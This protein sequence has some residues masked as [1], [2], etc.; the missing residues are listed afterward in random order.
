MAIKINGC[1]VIDDTKNWTGNP[2]AASAPS[3]CA[4]KYCGVS[5]LTPNLS[6]G[7]YYQLRACSDICVCTITNPSAC[8]YLY[9]DIASRCK[10]TIKLPANF[11]P[12]SVTATTNTSLAVSYVY[13]GT[14]WI[15]SSTSNTGFLVGSDKQNPCRWNLC[16]N[17]VF[18]CMDNVCDS[19]GNCYCSVYLDCTSKIQQPCCTAFAVDCAAVWYNNLNGKHPPVYVCYPG[20]PYPLGV[21]TA[22][23]E[24]PSGSCSYRAPALVAWDITPAGSLLDRT[25]T[26]VV[27]QLCFCAQIATAIPISHT[28]ANNALVSFQSQYSN[29]YVSVNKLDCVLNLNSVNPPTCC[30]M[31][32]ISIGTCCVCGHGFG[33]LISTKFHDMDKC[34]FPAMVLAGCCKFKFWKG[35]GACPICYIGSL[36]NLP[37]NSS[38]IPCT[39]SYILEISTTG[40]YLVMAVSCCYC[41]AAACSVADSSIVVY[42]DCFATSCV[43]GSCYV[44]IFQYKFNS[45][46]P[47]CMCCPIQPNYLATS[48]AIYSFDKELCHIFVYGCS[49]V[50]QCGCF[51]YIQTMFTRKTTGDSYVTSLPPIQSN[52]CIESGYGG[53]LCGWYWQPNCYAWQGFKGI[54]AE[55]CCMFGYYACSATCGCTKGLNYDPSTCGWRVGSVCWCDACYC[56]CGCEF[57]WNGQNH[58]HMIDSNGN[59]THPEYIPLP[60]LTTLYSS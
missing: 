24:C 53:C 33:C 38:T 46:T 22:I 35:T 8:P 40:E 36:H 39:C 52:C 27:G 58:R 54:C 21:A 25:R 59:I 12:G 32:T 7:N 49:A 23:A 18:K 37:A 48:N 5:D 1:T 17:L 9:L 57:A 15:K 47:F 4:C 42:R 29:Y 14:N 34:C 43:C 3:V 55:Q 50:P 60:S 20:H 31:Q 28:V 45:G 13:N 56:A 2:I 16:D 41:R 30:V 26:T 10:N 19:S 44:P 51:C 6:C 11:I